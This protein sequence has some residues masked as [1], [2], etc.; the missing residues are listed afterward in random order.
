MDPI[1]NAS[2]VEFYNTSFDLFE[3]NTL[4]SDPACA[5]SIAAYKREFHQWMQSQHADGAVLDIV[6]PKK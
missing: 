6:Y 2:P 5:K 1:R 4:A 3:I